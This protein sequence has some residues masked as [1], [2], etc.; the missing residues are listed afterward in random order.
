MAD[1]ENHTY[2]EAGKKRGK[3]HNSG[4]P[5]VSCLMRETADEKVTK[6]HLFQQGQGLITCGANYLVKRDKVTETDKKGNITFVQLC[7]YAAQL[8]SDT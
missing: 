4:G 6:G 2:V 8:R 3:G 5:V 7:L 1:R